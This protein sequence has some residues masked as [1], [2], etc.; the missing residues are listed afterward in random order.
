MVPEIV[1]FCFQLTTKYQVIVLYVSESALKLQITSGFLLSR[2][3]IPFYVWAFEVL[4]EQFNNTKWQGMGYRK[5]LFEL[6]NCSSYRIVRVTQICL[7]L[8]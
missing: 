1:R 3:H 4:K 8:D 5:K 7:D 6:S 2:R